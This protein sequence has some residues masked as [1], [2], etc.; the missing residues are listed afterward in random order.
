MASELLLSQAGKMHGNGK[1][2]FATQG[3]RSVVYT[4]EFVN[5]RFDG[6]GTCP[7]PTASLGSTH[8]AKHNLNL[9]VRWCVPVSGVLAD[10]RSVIYDGHFKDGKTSFP[11]PSPLGLVV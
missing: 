8:Q 6:Y 9:R 11:S 3:G 10:E 7:R 2:T 5:G 1:V 4:G